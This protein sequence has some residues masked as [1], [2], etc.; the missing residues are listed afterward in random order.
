MP[1]TRSKRS[2]PAGADSE[3]FETML[4]SLSI[5]FGLSNVGGEQL[6]TL[7]E[8]E[9]VDGTVLSACAHEENRAHRILFEAGIVDKK[10]LCLPTELFNDGV[11]GFNEKRKFWTDSQDSG[12]LF[13]YDYV[14]FI[15]FEQSHYSVFVAQDLAHA[16]PATDEKA[17]LLHLDSM[18]P[19]KARDDAGAFK[20]KLDVVR[21]EFIHCTATRQREPT[22]GALFGKIAPSPYEITE[23][24]EVFKPDVPRQPDGVSCGL[25]A[26][27]YIVEFARDP[28][29]RIKIKREGERCRLS[30]VWHKSTGFAP[31]QSFMTRDWFEPSTVKTLRKD[32]LCK[33]LMRIIADGGDANQGDNKVTA[34]KV[35]RA[36]CQILELDQA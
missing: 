25:F 31:K 12:S 1:T 28:P 23:Q 15:F 21:H 26:M 24:F 36:L 11:T 22:S 14:L 9:F 18:S 19:D 5:R 34:R 4:E 7:R 30:I 3:Q 8:G 10:V 20:V 27:K 29:F 13:E 17:L 32:F 35:F 16:N 33:L 6:D 2:R